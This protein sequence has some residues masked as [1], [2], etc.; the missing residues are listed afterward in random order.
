MATKRRSPFLANLDM[1]RKVPID[2][3]EGSKSGS[4]VSWMAL[5]GMFA[6]VVLETRDFLASSLQTDLTLDPSKELRVGVHFNITMMDLNCDFAAIDVVSFLGTKQENVT[7]NVQ[8]W[9]VD[10]NGVQQTV[11]HR[12]KRQHDIVLS[13]PKVTK[14]IEEL[15]DNGVHAVDLDEKSF[16]FALEEHEFVFVDFFASW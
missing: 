9:A 12:N 2:L 8:K 5:F 4:I 16:N 10:S 11:L 6:L 1:Y 14:T 3:L 13:D 7:K 15:H